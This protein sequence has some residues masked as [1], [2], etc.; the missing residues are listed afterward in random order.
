MRQAMTRLARPGAP[1]VLCIP[2]FATNSN[3]VAVHPDGV[4]LFDH[5]HAFGFDAWR[6]ELS[7]DGLAARALDELPDAIRHVQAET[8]AERV[9]LVG[10][11]L[12]GTLIYAALA[13]D[14]A[15]PVD[16]V[17]A[18]A[19]P[20][21]WVEKPPW[22]AAFGRL[23]PLLGRVPMRGTKLQARLALP[24]ASRL[25]PGLLRIYLN[26]DH[27]DLERA[28]V[29]FSIV[30][31][32]TPGMNLEI[33]RWVR[34]GHLV[35]RGL[36]IG[37]AAASWPRPVL[38]VTGNGDGI[39][40]PATCATAVAAFPGGEHLAVGRPDDPWSHAD[41]FVGHTARAEVFEPA[42]QFLAG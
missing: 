11:S 27:I 34:N 2:G 42:A 30:E 16:R 23:G 37:R 24:L 38:V 22:I 8:G 33:S 12:G 28:D 32:P 5:L 31:D 7:A 13:H 21:D 40:P 10:G 15:L 26:V 36:A 18:L 35:V 29:L 9:H 20:L 1:P 39:A 41:L 17:V 4:S 6:V 19:S 25:A 14:P 3:I